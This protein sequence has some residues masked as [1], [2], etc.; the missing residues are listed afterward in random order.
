MTVKSTNNSHMFKLA[1]R[2]TAMETSGNK[3]ELEAVILLCILVASRE[4]FLPCHFSI[5]RVTE[6]GAGTPWQGG[7][8]ISPLG[9]PLLHIWST[10]QQ[11]PCC[12]D[13][14]PLWHP[15]LCAGTQSSADEVTQE[16]KG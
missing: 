5:P 2:K 1:Q 6:C 15:E 9:F 3:R 16:Q 8:G 13:L 11:L 7:Q 14:A 10:Q 4:V 12:A